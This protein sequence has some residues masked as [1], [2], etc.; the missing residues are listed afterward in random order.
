MVSVPLNQTKFYKLAFYLCHIFGKLNISCKIENETA[1]VNEDV[2][3]NLIHEKY[4]HF[5]IIENT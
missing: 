5:E 2:T 3:M 1:I 4:I